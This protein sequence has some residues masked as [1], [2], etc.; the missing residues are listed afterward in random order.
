MD[1]MH[2]QLSDGRS[3]RTFN[4]I[5]DYNHEWLSIEVDFLPSARV[6]RALD[7]IIEWRGIGLQFIQPGRPQQNAYVKRYKMTC[8]YDWLNQY[9]FETIEKVQEAATAWL[10]TYN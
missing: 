10:W 5:D 1:F 2:D 7:R 4:V 8:R 3:F 6:I 9:I